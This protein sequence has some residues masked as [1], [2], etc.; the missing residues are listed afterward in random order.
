MF[1]CSCSP[2]ANVNIFSIM[3]LGKISALEKLLVK[4]NPYII[5]TVP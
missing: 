4:G 1:I 3:L 5:A 2:S